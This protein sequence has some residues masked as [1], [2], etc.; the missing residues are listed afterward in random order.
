MGRPRGV[1]WQEF[2]EAENDA[3]TGKERVK[4]KHCERVVSKR[5]HR[6]QQH[7]VGC[8]A[9]ARAVEL[10]LTTDEALHSITRGVQAHHHANNGVGIG[11]SVAILSM[12]GGLNLDAATALGGGGGEGSAGRR[13]LEPTTAGRQLEAQQV[14]ESVKEYYG[15]RLQRSGDSLLV[16]RH[17]ATQQHP[18]LEQILSK[19]PEEVASR[20]FG[21][22]N[23]LP[24]GSEGMRVLDLGCGSGRDAYVAS[25]LVGA[26]GYV[27][28]IDLT[29]EQIQVAERN[30]E[31]FTTPLGYRQPNL[32]FIEGHI[33]YLDKAGIA[34][35]SIDLVISNAVLN[36]SPNK[37]LVLKEVLRVLRP[38]G[39][40]Q[41]SDVFATRRLPESVRKHDVLHSE[42]IGGALYVEDFKRICRQIGFGEPREVS[43]TLLEVKNTGYAE[44]VGLAKFY[45]ITYRCFKV[46]HLE[47]GY[48]EED[49][50]H[51]ATYLGTIPGLPHGYHLD[52]KRFF[53]SLRPVR[54]GGNTA[55]VLKH[56][57]LKKYFNVHGDWSVHF[58]RFDD[59]AS[60]PSPVPAAGGGLSSEQAFRTTSGALFAQVDHP[61]PQAPQQQHT[62]DLNGADAAMF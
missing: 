17:N 48:H 9:Y 49:Y 5:A 31:E 44:M 28:G 15:H 14:Y 58:G 46:P 59:Q 19:V 23:P 42:C 26:R 60:G 62:T 13:H 18:F 61:M 35:R 54:V 40:F 39:E 50:G 33:E 2:D 32:R 29:P 56:S 41:F 51:V 8:K 53:E 10:K 30:I 1:I 47:S 45:S 11:G 36:L 37:E 24:L 12:G 43:R 57:W 20:Y 38:G 34:G 22:G 55:A 7:L 4:C 21:V 6:L 52:G 16:G 27:L 3:E 25:A